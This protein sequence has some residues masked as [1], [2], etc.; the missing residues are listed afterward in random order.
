MTGDFTISA[1]KEVIIN[2]NGHKITNKS[3]D[4]FTVNK[5]SKLTINGNG[6]VDNVSHGKTCI[7]NNGTVILNDGTYIRSKENGQ[8]SESSG[9]NSY[10]NI[11]N[12]GEMTINPNVEISQN[13]HYSSMIA[14]GYYDYTNT[15]PR[16]GYVSGTNHQNPSLIINGGTFAGGLNTI[17]MMMEPSLSSTTVRSPICLRQPYRII[18]WLK[19]KEVH[20]IRLVPLSMWWIMKVIMVQPMTWDR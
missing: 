7:Y 2:L 11:L 9:G 16:N 1:T 3:G 17:K 5:D 18:M 8:N 6:T 12:H 20:S 13:G 14:N 15:N 19:S 4:T 10:Y